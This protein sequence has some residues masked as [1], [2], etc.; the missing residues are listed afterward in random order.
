MRLPW[1][2]STT[3][4]NPE[5]LRSFLKILKILEGESWNSGTQAKFQILL[6]QHKIYGFGSQ[7]FYNSLTSSQIK[8]MDNPIPITFKQ[9]ESIFRSKKYVDPAMRGRQ[10]IN[11]L[12]KLG[13]VILVNNKIKTNLIILQK[14]L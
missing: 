6:I 2:I 7:Q 13:L 3:V 12:E 11:P 5:R 4:R 10:S 14:Q 1:S 9:A 8:L